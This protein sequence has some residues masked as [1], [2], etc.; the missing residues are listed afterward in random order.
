MPPIKSTT[1][2]LLISV[3]N[4]T[5]AIL[6]H[7]AGADIIDLKDPHRGALGKVNREIL[8]QTLNHPQLKNAVISTANND[9]IDGQPKQ[10]DNRIYFYKLGL[11]GSVTDPDWQSKLTRWH[12]GE[13]NKA[14]AVSFAD[15]KRSDSPPPHA[16]LDWAIENHA[17]GFLIDTAI[18]DGRGL[19]RWIS[20]E[21]LSAMILK[22][23]EAGLFVAIAGSLRLNDIPI[24]LEIKP[25]IIG[26]RGAACLKTDRQSR[27]CKEQI[28][29]LIA[30][31]Q[32][33]FQAAF[34]KA[35]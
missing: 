5:E 12:N 31:F 20:P 14:V 4:T 18:K 19:F 3:Q 35:Q 2:K 22:A 23:K 15:W 1:P 25:D 7:Q 34:Q 33:P 26:V 13:L 32:A 28:A 9:L 21:T 27:L 8:S 29:A 17:A 24:C 10:N 6:A 16:I 30:S 11:R